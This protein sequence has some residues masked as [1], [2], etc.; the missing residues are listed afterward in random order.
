[1]SLKFTLT[2]YAVNV[3]SIKHSGSGSQQHT[4][5]RVP[6]RPD[7]TGILSSPW[8][9]SYNVWEEK[10]LARSGAIHPR[11][12]TKFALSVPG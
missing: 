4:L 3:D 11:K 1:M 5:F 8:V 6:I 2:A 9:V 7:L 12:L 10:S